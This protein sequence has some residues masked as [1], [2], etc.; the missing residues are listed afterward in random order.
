MTRNRTTLTSVQVLRGA[1]ALFVAA[2]H[3]IAEMPRLRAYHGGFDENILQFRFGVD[4]FF[5]ISGFIM[6]YTT[7]DKPRT[8]SQ[9]LKFLVARFLRISPLYWMATALTI[10]IGLAI[11]SALN[12]DGMSTG[13]ILSS[14]FYLPHR[15]AN[16][17]YFPIVGPGW[18]LNYEMFF[19]LLFALAFL[20][21]W[22]SGLMALVG[23]LAGLVAIGAM[24]PGENVLLDYYANPILLEFAF[25]ALLGFAFVRGMLDRMLPFAVAAAVVGVVWVIG[26]H[27]FGFVD[28]RQRIFFYGVPATLLVF[29]AIVADGK[30]RGVG[31]AVLLA[32]GDASYSIYLTHL[33][34]ARAAGMVVGRLLPWCPLWL[35]F[36]ATLVAAGITGILVARFFEIP[37][38]HLTRRLSRS[39]RTRA[40]G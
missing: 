6:V 34:V 20:L 24:L 14:L 13:R 39:R 37:M 15:N 25:G 31:G 38:H 30:G 19:Y 23:T 36:V 4:L 21:P 11:P 35:F 8:A 10:A 1:A 32:L 27:V 2:G 18:T 16:G 12:H 29:A 28:M 40:A 3:I 5:V 7:C 33:F 9:G 22:R 26:L 17:D